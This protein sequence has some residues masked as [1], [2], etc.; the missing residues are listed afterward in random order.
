MDF[1][2]EFA[3]KY[4]DESITV[5]FSKYFNLTIGCEKDYTK[6]SASFSLTKREENDPHF[7]L[8]DNFED[9]HEEISEWES[10]LV[11]TLCWPVFINL[12]FPHRFMSTVYL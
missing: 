12:D 1:C 9:S 8:Y 3:E 6:I 2:R 11:E 5:P 10:R 4:G 7:V